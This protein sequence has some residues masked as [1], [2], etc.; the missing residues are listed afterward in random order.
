MSVCQ[1]TTEHSDYILSPQD[2]KVIIDGDNAFQPMMHK[3]MKCNCE[4]L[5]TH[6]KHT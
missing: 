5:W 2:F 1:R 6:L 3:T 4:L